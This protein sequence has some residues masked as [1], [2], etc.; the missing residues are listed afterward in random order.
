ML[1]VDTNVLIR[2]LVDDDA[3]QHQRAVD[4]FRAHRIWVSRTV[5]LESEWVLR[6][7]FGFEAREIASAFAGLTALPS[8]VCDGAD[9]IAQATEA[10]AEGMD[11]ADA[12]HLQCAHTAGCDEGFATFDARFIKKAAKRWTTIK[13]R[14]P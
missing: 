7:A 2:F 9:A 8:V 13:T 1:A 14:T 3:R 12:L 6:S 11:F 10:L 5:L 4:L